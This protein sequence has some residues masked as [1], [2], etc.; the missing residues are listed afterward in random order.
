M[1]AESGTDRLTYLIG[2]VGERIKGNLI[3]GAGTQVHV[4]AGSGAESVIWKVWVKLVDNVIAG[5]GTGVPAGDRYGAV[6]VMYLKR[7]ELNNRKIKYWIACRSGSEVFGAC[8][9]A[10]VRAGSGA[11]GVLY[12]NSDVMCKIKNRSGILKYL[13]RYAL[14]NVNVNLNLN[15][16]TGMHAHERAGSGAD[17][18]LHLSWSVG[19]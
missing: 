16:G 10:H 11:D 15:T 4:R 13:V 14:V 17:N 1:E 5:T 9:V 2:N 6:H 7:D 8:N 18:V 3:T 12:L 19:V